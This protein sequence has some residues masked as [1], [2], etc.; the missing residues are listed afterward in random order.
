MREMIGWRM[1]AGETST[2]WDSGA[3]DDSASVTFDDDVAVDPAVAR[4]LHVVVVGAGAFGGWTALHLLR[5]GARVTLL[6]SWGPGNGR[7]SSGGE[8]RAIRGVYGGDH[9][10]VAWTAKSLGMWRD[11]EADSGET[12]FR[13]AGV[14]WMVGGDERYVRASLTHL[15]ACGL[16]FEELSATEAAAR[17]P[18]INFDGVEWALLEHDAGFLY[19]GHACRVLRDR[20]VAEGGNYRQ[21]DVR[22]GAWTGGALSHLTLSDGTTL[23][24][25]QFVFA[26]GPWLGGMFPDVIGDLIVPTRQEVYYMG[27][28]A[29]DSRFNEGNIPVWIDFGETIYYGFPATSTRG[30]KIADDTRGPPLDPT[31]ADRLPSA[32]AVRRA[33]RHL[34]YRF[35]ALAGAPLIEARVCQ[36]ANTPDGHFIVDRHPSADNVWLVGGGSGHGFKLGPAL[37]DFVARRV[38]T[39]RDTHPLLSLQRFERS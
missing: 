15:S 39:G 38:L 17:F 12:F 24:A 13:R 8:T 6:D 18:Q 21:H 30:F 22:V 2:Q 11:F 28:P 7:S 19:A 4:S 32:E 14:L 27:T 31:N 36:Y 29:G 37:G 34:E 33:Q 16:S 20:F 23:S 10:Y 25:D 9:A 1:R 26:C 35:P 5:A 3:V